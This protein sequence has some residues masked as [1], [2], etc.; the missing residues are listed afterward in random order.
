MV[1]N[2]MSAKLIRE[3]VVLNL[4]EPY[5]K[6]L[7]RSYCFVLGLLLVNSNA[8]SQAISWEEGNSG[9]VVGQGGASVKT[10]H[11]VSNRDITNARLRVGPRLA[12]NVEVVSDV[13]ETLV[14]GE[15]YTATVRVSALDDAHIRERRGIL[16]ITG[17]TTTSR[18]RILRFFRRPLLSPF[19]FRVGIWE[20]VSDSGI[21]LAIAIP[22]NWSI[23]ELSSNTIALSNVVELSEFSDQS[24]QTESRFL[25]RRIVGANSTQL[26]PQAW[27]DSFFQDGFALDPIAQESVSVGGR[28]ALRMETIEIGRNVHYYIQEGADIIEVTFGLYAEQFLDEYQI[29]LNSTT[30]IG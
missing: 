11:F 12:G 30:P 8:L 13:P 23:V 20:G 2:E 10:I 21:G 18:N 3:S 28:D 4:M 15:R 7:V 14:A 9:A 27:A 5:M 24:L 6:R 19:K 17:R 25:A 16:V 22:E 1:L 29:L 26:P